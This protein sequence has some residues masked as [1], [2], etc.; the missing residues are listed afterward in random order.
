MRTSFVINSKNKPL[1]TLSLVKSIFACNINSEVIVM[2][3]STDRVVD[4]LIK[5][6]EKELVSGDLKIISLNKKVGHSTKRLKALEHITG[7]FV[8]FLYGGDKINK[9]KFIKASD[10]IQD[11]DVDIFEFDVS[12]L[13]KTKIN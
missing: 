1:Q 5:E 8:T 7:D 9:K 13:G 2:D 3:S 4:M 10:Y 12:Y 11:V 6:F